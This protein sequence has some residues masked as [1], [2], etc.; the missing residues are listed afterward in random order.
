M[1]MSQARLLSS[2][3]GGLEQVWRMKLPAAPQFLCPMDTLKP[4]PAVS[5]YT[6]VQPF[7]LLSTE[8]LMLQLSVLYL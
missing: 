8:V 5:D 2:R 6:L 7:N 4:F 1:V 3:K